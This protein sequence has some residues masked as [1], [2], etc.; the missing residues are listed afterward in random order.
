MTL[1]VATG[2]P[3]PRFTDEQHLVSGSQHEEALYQNEVPAWAPGMLGHLYGSLYGVLPALQALANNASQGIFT[4]LR[5]D[6]ATN[7]G[8]PDILLMFRRCE[9][10]VSVLN[11]GMELGQASIDAFCRYVFAVMPGTAQIDFHAIALSDT[12]RSPAAGSSSGARPCLR[13]PCTEDIVIHLPE[14]S[15]DYL[16]Q[17]S[18]ATRK[19]IRKHLSRA[20]ET[21]PGF[22]HHVVPGAALGEAL[23]RRVVSFNHARMARQGRDSAIDEHATQELIRL[24]R[25]HGEAGVI[26]SGPRLYAGTLACRLGDDVFSLVNAHDPRFDHLGLG[27]ICRHLMILHAIKTGARRFH[28]LGGNFPAKRATLAER[29][30]LHH[31]TVYRTRRAMLRDFKGIAQHAVN[32]WALRLHCWMEDQ[33]AAVPPGRTG[34]MIGALRKRLGRRHARSQQRTATA[35]GTPPGTSFIA[36][37]NR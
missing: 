14:S 23:L 13:W 3:M 24:I 4:Y 5:R 7:A 10:K 34:R 26:V 33:Q 22:S 27:N 12:E 19:S 35:R 17:L 1:N 16:S 21:L 20:Q 9:H 32:A 6:A 37:E 28:L 11:E 29:Q 31:L 2:E 36:P 30:L 8:L 25:A 18:K 15:E